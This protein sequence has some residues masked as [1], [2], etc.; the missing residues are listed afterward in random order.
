M[1]TFT[2]LL[3]AGGLNKRMNRFPK[4]EL[5]IGHETM[6]QRSIRFL[7]GYSKEIIIVSGG[8]YRFPRLDQDLIPIRVVYD[9]TPFLGPLNGIFTGL[10]ES[11]HHYHFVIAADMPFFS[12]EFA[13]Y[14]VELAV[15]NQV[16]LVI[17]EWKGKLQPLHGVYAKTLVK[18]M[19]KDLSVGKNSLIKWIFEQKNKMIIDEQIVAQFNHSGR[20]FFNMN[21][22]EDYDQA[23]VWIREEEREKRDVKGN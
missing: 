8:E 10:M 20:M 3:L 6:L 14:M 18:S 7:R 1:M 5:M 9:P 19:K 22:K 21:Y 2:S 15:S 23:L 17:P 12:M 11:N 13:Q 16:D 4:W